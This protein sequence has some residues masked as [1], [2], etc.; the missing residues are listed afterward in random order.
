MDNQVT[1]FATVILAVV[2]LAG[3]SWTII[4]SPVADYQKYFAFTILILVF[5][6][7]YIHLFFKRK[8]EK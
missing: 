2:G 6:F 3:L 4:V 8:N 7:V 1:V 5:L